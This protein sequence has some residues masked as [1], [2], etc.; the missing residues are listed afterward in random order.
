MELVR[1]E[2]MS[3]REVLSQSLKESAWL[4][5]LALIFVAYAL[6][7]AVVGDDL[8]RALSPMFHPTIGR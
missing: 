2:P 1:R 6:L 8:A 5:G 7:M 3:T 4:L